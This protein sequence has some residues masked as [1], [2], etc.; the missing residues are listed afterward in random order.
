MRITLV[1]TMMPID[2]TKLADEFITC[3]AVHLQ[4]LAVAATL[5][6]GSAHCVEELVLSTKQWLGH[7]LH[8]PVTGDLE[9]ARTSIVP[10][11]YT[12][13]AREA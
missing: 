9:N 2:G 5:H 11:S 1:V 13:L 3:V 7:V 10:K 6:D 12:D 8:F 4:W